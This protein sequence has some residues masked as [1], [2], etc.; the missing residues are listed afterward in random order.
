[1]Y[2]MED[3]WELDCHHSK[4]INIIKE[5]IPSDEFSEK[6][7]TKD[8]WIHYHSKNPRAKINRP[9]I[10]KWFFEPFG[11]KTIIHLKLDLFPSF[12]KRSRLLFALL[13]VL[14]LALAYIDLDGL[15]QNNKILLICTLVQLIFTVSCIF[16]ILVLFLKLL[17][18]KSAKLFIRDDILGNIFYKSDKSPKAIYTGISY[19]DFPFLLFLIS[20][21][22]V[23]SVFLFSKG[24]PDVKLILNQPIFFIFI[25]PLLLIL[26][27]TLF[28]GIFKSTHL[29]RIFFILNALGP[30][31]IFI[32]YGLIPLMVL[33]PSSQSHLRAKEHRIAALEVNNKISENKDIH[34]KSRLANDLK[35]IKFACFTQASV[36]LV[37]W[38]SILLIILLL[39]WF[40]VL[41][42]KLFFKELDKYKSANQNSVYFKALTKNEPIW[43]IS[44]LALWL[45]FLVCNLLVTYLTISEF[46]FALFYYKMPFIKTIINAIFDY[47]YCIIL[48]F[49]PLTSDNTASVLSRTVM[50]AHSL[51]LS[52]LL[53]KSILIRFNS[54]NSLKKEVKQSNNINK[55]DALLKAIAKCSQRQQNFPK[56]TLT[57]EI[58]F[59]SRWEPF[60]KNHSF[61]RLHTNSKY[62]LRNENEVK[63]FLAHELY[64]CLHHNRIFFLLNWLS[65]YTLC[66]SGFLLSLLN[67][68]KM[69]Y[70]ADNF[71]P[72][73]IP[74]IDIENAFI[75]IANAIEY[76]KMRKKV[77][78][79]SL[80][81]IQR[82][83][84]KGEKSKIKIL[85][86]HFSG[87]GD[88]LK[89]CHPFIDYRIDKIKSMR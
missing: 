27:F 80:S 35:K 2:K 52:L 54:Y 68:Q 49:N 40:L 42:P 76:D 84:R 37:L 9:Q 19:P 8:G 3:V 44:V 12:K 23:L 59:S 5:L 64:H 34:Y 36:H 70:E 87:T 26:I 62:I 20:I 60:S 67:F 28:Y 10:M 31:M 6:T 21:S 1:M 32:L 85:L 61:I 51:P 75:N 78:S 53:T 74:I 15:I 66:G 56:V 24:I 50:A 73:N 86:E 55:Y 88:I 18:Y 16:T 45:I 25:I 47:F 38:S 46:I 89:Y 83:S 79:H 71:I 77:K 30:I 17:D 39:F 13:S 4:A 72:K 41:D 81:I 69:E 29:A 43:F 57:D 14:F 48:L 7:D 33:I 58:D 63:T 65:T 22:L 11:E 82:F